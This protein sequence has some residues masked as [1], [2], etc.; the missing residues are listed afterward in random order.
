ML[1]AGVAGPAG[2][3]H[4]APARRGRVGLRRAAAAREQVE[5]LGATFLEIELPDE[6]AEGEGG[7][8][9]EL[10]EEAHRREQELV[11]RHVAESDV[12]V[13]TALIPGRPAPVLVTPR[14]SRRCARAR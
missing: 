2:D 7:Y 8:A 4:G 6:D 13:T 12:V 11:A 10:S 1:G 14:W 5:S 3:R 9:K